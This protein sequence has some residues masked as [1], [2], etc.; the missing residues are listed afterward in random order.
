M[1]TEVLWSSKSDEWSTPQYLFDELDREFHFTLD[2]CADAENH[3]CDR[4]Y[5]K[6][7][8][9]LKQSWG[10]GGGILQSTLQSDRQVGE[11]SVGRSKSERYDMCLAD[12]RKDRHKM[13]SRIHTEPCR[14][15]VHQR[16]TEIRGCDRKCS[17]S[18][19]GLYILWTGNICKEI[20]G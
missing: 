11:E 8:D 20:E 15:A 16:Q 5:T 14:G 10:G 7:Q 12:T 17:V 19:H 18:E 1:K 6:E 13:V 3:K 9:G 2:P 4:Y